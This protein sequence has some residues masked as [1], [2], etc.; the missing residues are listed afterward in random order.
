MDFHPHNK[1]ATNSQYM[2]EKLTA[3][4]GGKKSEPGNFLAGLRQSCFPEGEAPSLFASLFFNIFL[5]FVAYTICRIEFL[6]EN[7]QYFLQAI[8]DRRLSYLFLSALRFDTPGIF[9]SN[10]VY[11]LLLLLPLHYKERPGYYLFCKYLFLIVNS[12][13]IIANLADSIYFPYTLR[14][15][16]WDVISEFSHEE[17]LPKIFLTELMSHWYVSLTAI[18]L[19]WG[20]WHCYVSPS[21]VRL[22]GKHQ[23][24]QYYS[25]LSGLLILA[26]LFTVGA[27][28]GGWLN[29]WEL[30]VIACLLLYIAFLL[31]RKRHIP[32]TLWAKAITCLSAILIVLAPIGGFRHRDI[33]PIALSNASGFTRHPN[34]TA[35]ILNTPFSIIRTINANAFFDPGYFPDKHE[36]ETIYTP[37]HYPVINADTLPQ[38][39]YNKKNVVIIII[40]SFGHEYIGALNKDILG[41]DHKGFTP[42]TDSLINKSAVW[43][44][45]FSNGRKSIDGMP[46][47][48]AGIPMLVKPFILTSSALNRLEGLPAILRKQGYET[49]FFHG[50]R[51]G[52]M[53]FDGFARSVGFNR[54]YG[55]ENFDNDPR[56]SSE[57]DFDGYWAIWDEPFLQYYALE[58]SRLPQP[59]MTAVFTASSHH[60]FNIPE[61]YSGQ[62]PEG[63]LPIHKC[64]GYTDYALSRFFETARRQP[65]YNNTIFVI[66][67][68]HTNQSDHPEYKTDLGTFRSPIIIFSPEGDIPAGMNSG[69][70]QQTDIMPTVLGLLKLRI[71]YLAFGCDLFS[72]PTDR[73]WAISYTNGIYQYVSRDRVLQFDGK[74]SVGLYSLSDYRMLKN[75]LPCEPKTAALLEKQLKAVIQQYMD[76]MISNRLTAE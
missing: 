71:P 70:A 30:Y 23:Y 15:T 56:F 40:E 9:Y 29:H 8:S 43:Q 62:F 59:F 37:L 18:L 31:F 50:A 44:H 2:S 36:L 61:K 54:Y 51:T 41:T 22:Q 69:V 3:L 52:S 57:K 75:L 47:I 64:I 11:I 72:T 48:L 45:S 24:F 55:R 10:S 6:L 1:S 12:F 26:A 65:W 28:R 53:G 33:R 58:M 14:R 20:L 13:A 46:S 16:T 38:L 5:V 32:F 7:L 73:T 39:A 49:A 27:V 67:N 68:D 19:I 74:K 66:T 35:L 42:F 76:R 34:E 60:P 25:S 4:S 17:N 63:N 21:P